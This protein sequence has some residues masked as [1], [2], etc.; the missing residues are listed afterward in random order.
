MRALSRIEFYLN[1]S[2]RDR[3][4]GV[5][6]VMVLLVLLALAII[7]TP[8]VISMAL[9]EKSSI[10]FEGGVKARRAAEGARNHALARLHETHRAVENEIVARSAPEGDILEEYENKGVLDEESKQTKASIKIRSNTKRRSTTKD[11][12]RRRGT[13]IREDL[14]EK[15]PR[16]TG[17]RRNRR[18]V[19]LTGENHGLPGMSQSRVGPTE[20]SFD[21]D[22][23]LASDI[24]SEVT[25][26][27]SAPS[28]STSLEEEIVSTSKNRIVI[29]DKAIFKNP[30]GVYATSRVVDEQGKV[31]IN[32][33]PAN[34][35]AS[36]FGSTML[37]QP[38]DL[39]DDE[40]VVD[41]ASVFR[42]DGNPKTIDGA[43]V[44]TKRGENWGEVVTY[45]D[46]RGNKLT[47]LFRGAFFSVPRKGAA[48][49]RYP[50]HT[51]VWDLRGWKVA[52]HRMRAG[53][54]NGFTSEKLH[55]FQSI[56]AIREIAN[57]QV[58]SLFLGRYRGEGLTREFL[59]SNGIKAK[60]LA[61]VGLD[62]AL[63]ESEESYESGYLKLQLDQAFSILRKKRL[64]SLSL[65]IKRALGP[66]AVIEFAN[67]VEHLS[68]KE[69]R[70]AAEELEDVLK[71][72]K[73]R[74]S[75][76]NKDYLIACL[77]NL[78]EVYKTPGIETITPQEFEHIR[79]HITVTSRRA[80]EWSEAQT[81]LNT[82]TPSS[83]AAEEKE[84]L[85]VPRPG[86]HG[87]GTLVRLRHR[88][89]P[90]KPE[91]NI[92]LGG[93]PKGFYLMFPTFRSY[94]KGDCLVD[95]YER[96]PVNV[97][98][99]SLKVLEAVFTGVTH[100]KAAR[101]KAEKGANR[102]YV[103]PGVV[104]P[105]EAKALAA[106]VYGGRPYKGIGDLRDVIE[107]AAGGT[108]DGL[109]AQALIVNAVQP[110]HDLLKVSTLGF[111][112]DFGDIY[113]IESRGIIRDDAG[114]EIYRTAFREIVDVSPARPL[115]YTLFSQADFTTEL[116]YRSPT[117]SIPSQLAY[118]EDHI[119]N[120]VNYPGMESHL[121]RTT[122]VHLKTHTQVTFNRGGGGIRG[123]TQGNN[124]TLDEFP[125]AGGEVGTLRLEMGETWPSKFGVGSVG[126]RG[127]IFNFRGGRNET[128][129]LPGGEPWA[130]NISLGGGNQNFQRGPQPRG[131]SR[132]T[133]TPGT[134][135]DLT[136]VPSAI[137]AWVRF[138]T[139][140]QALSYDG[141][142][143]L[144]D[145]GFEERR[146]RISLL[147]D[148]GRQEFV[149]RMFDNSLPDPSIA[150]E[151]QK[152]EVRARKPLELYTWYH[153]KM[154]W[155][156]MYRGGLQ[157]F[158][159]GLP[160]GRSNFETDLAGDLAISSRNLPIANS[161]ILPREGVARVGSELVEYSGGRIR[162]QP[163]SYFQKWL[164]AEENRKAQLRA[165]QQA[166][167]TN[168][169]GGTRTLNAAQ[170]M[171]SSLQSSV[172]RGSMGDDA[173]NRRASVRTNHKSGTPVSLHGYSLEVVRKTRQSPTSTL[174]QVG[175]GI[176]LGQGGLRLKED[177]LPW[178]FPDD[179]SGPV[180]YQIELN[181]G[182]ATPG[183][184]GPNPLPPVGGR[185][186]NPNNQGQNQ[187]QSVPIAAPVF[188]LQNPQN[189][190]NQG[191]TLAAPCPDFDQ[192]QATL[193]QRLGAIPNSQQLIQ[194]LV[195]NAR[196]FSSVFQWGGQTYNAA[197]FFQSRGVVSTH[198][199]SLRYQKTS[200]DANHSATQSGAFIR[201]ANINGYINVNQYN[202]AVHGPPTGR[203]VVL[204]Q[205]QTVGLQMNSR[206]PQGQGPLTA[207]SHRSR[208]RLQSVLVNGSAETLYPRA[209]LIEM[210]GSPAPWHKPQRP[211]LRGS[212][213]F[214]NVHPD[215]TVEW[216]RYH[217]TENDM[218]IHPGGSTHRDYPR[219]RN[220]MYHRGA[221]PPG[222]STG[223]TR[224]AFGGR[225]APAGEPARQVVELMKG[226]AGYGDYV[227]IVTDDPG[228]P[229]SGPFRVFR[230][231]EREDGRFFVSL[232][233][234]GDGQGYQPFTLNQPYYKGGGNRT[235][236]VKFPTGSLPSMGS[237][238]LVIFG[239]AVRGSFNGGNQIGGTHQEAEEEPKTGHVIDEVK[240]TSNYYYHHGEFAR[241]ASLGRFVVV[242]LENG[243]VRRVQTSDGGEALTGSIS[244]GRT[245]SRANPMEVLVVFTGD[246]RG[247]YLFAQNEKHGVV[248][249]NEEFF[250]F[251]NPNAQSSNNGGRRSAAQGGAAQGGHGSGSLQNLRPV[252]TNTNQAPGV[253]NL[254]F[255]GQSKPQNRTRR[256]SIQ[257]GV[258]GFFEREGFARINY[259]SCQLGGFREIF[260]YQSRNGGNFNN[261]LRGQFSTSLYWTEGNEN[262]AVQIQQNQQAARQGL[263]VNN[264]SPFRG[265][266]QNITT[267]IRLIGRALLGSR[268]Q[269]H[270]FGDQISLAYHVDMTEIQGPMT[271]V[272]IPVLTTE[273][274][275][276]VG[277]LLMDSARGD[278][279]FEMVAYTGR[280]GKNLFRRPLDE[281]GRGVCRA[282]FGTVPSGVGR[283]MFA[284]AM[285]YRYFDR[286]QA[287]ADSPYFAYFQKAFREPGALWRKLAWKEQEQPNRRNRLS[288]LVMAVR[289]DGKPDWSA[290]P[291]NKPGGLYLIEGGNTGRNSLPGKV[292]NVVADQMEVRVYFRFK[293]GAFQRVSADHFRDDWKESPVLESLLIEYEKSGKVLRREESDF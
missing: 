172:K 177:L 187:I 97:N 73:R 186:P 143:I 54:M 263:Q 103:S 229:G 208:L 33:A 72:R 283:G 274:F 55:R 202:F 270:G 1:H 141:L 49:L 290:T 210:R 245:I 161:Q 192:L 60:D 238:K 201:A 47:G 150:E 154:A 239:D 234:P 111:C 26:P 271:D 63:F 265:S 253:S 272:G 214:S 19:G 80:A 162:E 130:V 259:N 96:H 159:D 135:F 247:T 157:L 58:S 213:V 178:V 45:R 119:Y 235:K 240:V 250:F 117:R 216:I 147:Y 59:V 115:R 126:G 279:R 153:I 20:K 43:V 114:G 118:P 148:R 17:D 269:T 276:D 62:P 226:G 139:F 136:R 179:V 127:G 32:S 110:N 220:H 160:V 128:L 61:K 51:M 218:F 64:S 101:S 70:Q 223:D 134:T 206:F 87:G 140:P 131:T 209:G 168:V 281:R 34:V 268:P 190:N 152:I 248:R 181:Q 185:N 36:L 52:Y 122:P 215:D 76:I 98:T 275:P 169:P 24:P 112:Y 262:R 71:K 219:N 293:T 65:K 105:H 224:G 280:L 82:I 77:K 197:D 231:L 236:L 99:A 89:Q 11:R 184:Q 254:Y 113:T 182:P 155:D 149:A 193:A 266:L 244:R 225:G 129:D 108:I 92:S 174:C 46:R 273:G 18:N 44:I 4:Q 75:R 191:R 255:G 286:Y 2:I 288:D 69:A 48:S 104:L 284:Y 40:M 85:Q 165:Q 252:N 133:P 100:V 204:C 196:I 42:S 116:F 230:V 21:Q 267:R 88:G 166:Q 27:D 3:R 173:G 243:R 175:N 29:E 35:I 8:F 81:L 291:T 56:E 260:Y 124:G 257:S 207:M 227:S 194:L 102:G 144:M 30:R 211:D 5:A 146:N 145:A 138:R 90:D 142:L 50:T 38:F 9:Q 183:G 84:S 39:K 195:Q 277:Y 107:G 121:V 57:W 233:A 109:D 23:E 289:F 164:V 10:Q 12:R 67:R 163:T 199:G 125:V 170:V 237:G 53:A 28:Y 249:I 212:S 217:W 278:D 176:V 132:G 188:E 78:G 228:D 198:Q 120:S 86:Y 123:G 258:N 285:P 189:P 6:I 232:Y 167:N 31:N 264:Q 83:V 242:P 25:L 15:A 41:D 203:I 156:G 287:K 95:F 251:E 68:T 106:A 200:L 94:T 7:G 137:E 205:A 246:A 37:I 14:G 241:D 91:Y 79:E 171:S 261:C 16:R 221:S 22:S 66:R 74:S 158:I 256:W 180:H 151:D 222:M 292:F 282:A 13:V 93:G